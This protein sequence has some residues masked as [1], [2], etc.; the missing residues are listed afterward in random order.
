MSVNPSGESDSNS[1]KADF[2]KHA[3]AGSN[4]SLGQLFEAYRGYLWMLADAELGTDLK[5]KASPSD[6]VQDSF[7]EAKRNFPEFDG[8]TPAE[9]QAWVR[10]TLLNNV[11]DVGREYRG[12]E[13]RDISREVAGTADQAGDSSAAIAGDDSSASS[14]AMNHEQLDAVRDAI[15]KLPVH[16]QD[17]IQWRSYELQTFEE[18]GERMNRSAEAARKLW[19]RAVE[20]LQQKLDSPNASTA[21]GSG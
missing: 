3:Q 9:F 16:Y 20:L 11:A 18:I 21:V 10:R 7:L 15:R 5:V 14:V 17:V 6:L 8:K 13:K 2:L 4:S 1:A 19:V 12:T